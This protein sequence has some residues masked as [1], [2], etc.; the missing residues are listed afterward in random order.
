[1]SLFKRV[2]YTEHCMGIKVHSCVLRS[3]A[4]RDANSR[5]SLHKSGGKGVLSDREK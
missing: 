5:V 1:M 3:L 2:L 4:K